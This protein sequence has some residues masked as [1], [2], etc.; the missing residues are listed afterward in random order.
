ME[1]NPLNIKV[2]TQREGIGTDR[3]SNV[4]IT[5]PSGNVIPSTGLGEP[6]PITNVSTGSENN[7]ETLR[8]SHLRSQE[9]GLQEKY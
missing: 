7:F 8:D 1:P 2:R 5:Q 3:E 9:Q 6:T 4:P